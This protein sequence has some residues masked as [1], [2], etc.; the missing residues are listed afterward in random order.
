METRD[1]DSRLRD[2]FEASIAL[3][4]E[5]SLEALLQKI[6]ETAASLTG[7]RYA[8]LGVIDET[9]ALARALRHDR[10][11]RGDRTSDRRPA[12]RPRHPRR[13][14][15]RRATAAPRPPR[16]RPA[17][18]RL[19]AEPPADGVVPRRA[20]RSCAGRLRQPLPDREAGRRVV[21]RRRRGARHAP[22][23]PGRRRDR[24]RAPLRVRDALV[25]PARV[26]ARDRALDGRGDRARPAARARLP[27]GA[28]AD[29]RAP[30]ARRAGRPRRRPR[31]RRDRECGGRGRALLGH[32]SEP[33]RARRCG[34]VLQRRQSARID[35]LLDDPEVAQDEA[36]RDGG[37]NRACTCRSSRAAAR[38]ASIAVHDKLGGD[39]RF[40]D[41][42]L[43]LVEIFA[44]PRSRRRRRSRSASHATP[45]VESSTR[46]NPSGGGSRSSCTT[47]RGRR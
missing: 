36:R 10:R 6:V 43:R 7:A 31:D 5:L 35:S 32:R 19:P 41:G 39:A 4:S 2:L 14:D 46:R 47:R 23:R 9:G 30:R 12:A 38:S 22:R 24:E 16:R 37:P 8:A 3:N 17:L 44:S 21:H 1:S 13:A 18:G 11:R 40:S 29:R 15:P 28:R 42:D 20:G 33:R 27:A 34:R 26:A 25:A 45:S